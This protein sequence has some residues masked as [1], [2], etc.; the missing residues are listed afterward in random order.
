MQLD[1]KIPLSL[2]DVVDIVAPSQALISNRE[3]IYVTYPD[4][5][6]PKA[7]EV[8]GSRVNK[9]RKK[10]SIMT[11]EEVQDTKPTKLALALKPRT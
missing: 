10:L 3:Q 9:H 5:A 6:G 2:G 4:L 7:L 1:K 8:K 11:E